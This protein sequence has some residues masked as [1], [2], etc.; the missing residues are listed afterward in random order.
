MAFAT[1]DLIDKF[2]TLSADLGNTTSAVTDNDMSD[3]TNDLDAFT[4]TEDASW[5]LCILI[6]Q[7]A[8]LPTDQTAFHVHARRMSV[9][10]TNDAPLPLEGVNLGEFIGSIPVDG[11]VAV[12]TD[13]LMVSKWLRLPNSKSSQ[14]YNF[15]LENQSGQTLSA[16]WE[17]YV[18]T[19]GMGP[20]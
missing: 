15:Y 4:N 13:T 5:C 7:W 18:S 6:G 9:Q 2:G 16:G 10:S 3:G 17:F 8:T 20:Q 12:T 1:D 11:N 19:V 14:I